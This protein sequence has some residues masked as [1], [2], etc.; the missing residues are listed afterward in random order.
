MT[1]QATRTVAVVFPSW[2]HDVMSREFE[3]AVRRITDIAPLVEMAAPGLVV[4]SARGPS[5]YFGGDDALAARVMEMCTAADATCGVGVAGSRFAAVAAAR[6]S[7]SRGRACVVDACVTGDF[8]DALPVAALTEAAGIDPDVVDLLSRLGLSRC[9][10]VRALGEEA[11]I[12][13]FGLEGRRVH[14]LVSG[15]DVEH[16]SPGP[17]PSDFA[18]AATFDDALSSV[19]AVAWSARATIEG[20]LGE[21]S[22]HGLQVVRLS[23]VCETDHAERNQRI[24]GEPRGF[25]VS[26]ACRALAVQLDGWLADET[27]DPD[28]P[29]GGVVRLEVTP[30]EC[31][32]SLVVQPLLWGGQ[33]ENVERVARAVSMA[34]AAVPD[35][36]ISVPCWEGGRDTARAWSLVDASLIDF[37]DIEA[38][39]E[40]V[41]VG[42]GAPRA[43]TG[44]VPSPS[45]AAVSMSPHPVRLIDADGSDVVVTGRHEFSSPPATVEV[46]DNVWNVERAAGPW[47]VEERWWDPRRRRRLARVQVLVRHPRFGVGVLLLGIE[48]G[49]WSLLGRY[50]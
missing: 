22:A 5:R 36:V 40:R 18:R 49:T 41:S 33:Q 45:P 47:P 13:R 19:E 11:L 23:L 16:L 8:V 46:G 38:A 1:M 31:R 34:R 20:V 35:V 3:A 21:V 28:A 10:A 29:T 26:A 43:W 12:D 44:A 6:L 25:S 30:L 2:L 32:E 42:N 48:N 9:G 50:D 14:V 37:D 24:W 17:P 7:S 4:F 15:H 27:A 39:Q